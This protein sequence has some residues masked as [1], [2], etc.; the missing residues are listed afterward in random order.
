MELQQ[1]TYQADGT[2]LTGFL[3]RPARA[4]PAPGI[5]VAHEAPGVSDHVKARAQQLAAQGYVAFALDMYGR[6]NLPLEEAR[7]ASHELMAD[8]GRLRRRAAA[9]LDVLAHEPRCDRARLAA[10]GFCLGGIVA[11]ELAR[12]GAPIR[13][14]VGLHPGLRR[15]AGS[16]GGPISAKVLM[17][18][19]QNDPVAP[20][21]ERA[22]F[23]KEMTEAGADWQMLL[24]G[25][26]GH[27]FT[28]PAIDALGFPGFAYDAR[29]DR[30]AW[31]ATL[32]LLDEV[33]A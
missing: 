25:G 33:L 18:I 32:D 9:A 29:A 7:Q 8:A 10:I 19:G 23:A 20:V 6:H 26:V 11:L 22:A 14:A 3:A 16:T 31:R 27:S 21:E 13:A 4:D 24:L 15:P 28:N 12:A 30:R 17:I 2:D 5:L 1:I